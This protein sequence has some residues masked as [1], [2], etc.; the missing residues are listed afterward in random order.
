ML[1]KYEYGYVHKSVDKYDYDEAMDFGIVYADDF[2]EAQNKVWDLIP[3]DYIICQ[4]KRCP[5]VTVVLCDARHEMPENDGAIFDT[6]ID[7][8]DVRGLERIA[9]RYVNGIEELTLYVTGLTVALVAVINACRIW[10]VKL[11]L[12]HYDRESGN[13]YPQKVV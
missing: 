7:P 8:L 2:V 1:K 12:M 3:N 11:T 9:N 10:N 4:F 5:A 6:T 13:Y